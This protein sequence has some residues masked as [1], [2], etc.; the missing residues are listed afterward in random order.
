VRDNGIGISED[1]KRNYNAVHGLRGMRERAAY[2]GGRID[3]TSAPNR[4]TKINVTF[5]KAAIANAAK[6]ARA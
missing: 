4:G 3:I 2:L 1:K 6:A 5:P